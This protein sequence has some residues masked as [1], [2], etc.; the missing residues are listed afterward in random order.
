MDLLPRDLH[1]SI[2]LLLDIK[3]VG[4]ACLVSKEF[5]RIFS[6]ERHWEIRFKKDYR[7]NEK[8]FDLTWKETYGE[9]FTDFLQTCDILIEGMKIGWIWRTRD[10]TYKDLVKRATKTYPGDWNYAYFIR[11]MADEQDGELC[12]IS[13]NLEISRFTEHIVQGDRVSI[14]LSHDKTWRLRFKYEGEFFSYWLSAERTVGGF[15]EW[16]FE[17]F[18]FCIY[19]SRKTSSG[20]RFDNVEVIAKEFCEKNAMKFLAEKDIGDREVIGIHNSHH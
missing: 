19:M 15:C 5:N 1:I 9:I 17:R 11:E 18:P 2:S 8:P 4:M 16:I 3:D 6:D 7:F 14:S 10:C 20:R 13:D 12:L